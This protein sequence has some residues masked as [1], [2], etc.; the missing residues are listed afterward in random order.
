MKPF[1]GLIRQNLMLRSV[2]RPLT[3]TRPSLLR[4]LHNTV[5]RSP[6]V[7][8]QWSEPTSNGLVP[9]VIEQT[10]CS[11]FHFT[12]QSLFSNPRFSHREEVNAH[13]IFSPV[14]FESVLSCSMVPSVAFIYELV[15]LDELCFRFGT[16][17]PRSSLH[18]SSS[19]RQ[20][21]RLNP[22]IYT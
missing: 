21:K 7:T 19:S 6:F 11:L 13:T 22:F 5:P 18:N 14:F 8:S 3:Q 4:N 1:V 16:Q 15:S 17:T 9:I 10:V 2:F 12:F 20:R